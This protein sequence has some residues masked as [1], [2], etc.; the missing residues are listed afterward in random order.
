MANNINEEEQTNIT[1]ELF[2]L[3]EYA[4]WELFHFN[5]LKKSTKPIQK[6]L[7]I[8]DKDTLKQWK[9]KTGYNYFKKNIFNY[10][11]TTNKLKNQKEKI[12]VEN[13]KLN[14]IWKKTLSDKKINLKEN[15]NSINKKD[16]G[17]F[18]IN[19]KEKQIDGN[20]NYEIISAKL[21]EIF[22]PFINYKITING[23]YYKGKLTIPLNYKNKINNNIKGGNYLEVFYINNKNE[24]EDM[25]YILPDD[26]NICNELEQEIINDNIENLIKNIFSNITEKEKIKEF[27]HCGEDGNNI[28]YKVLNKK[29]FLTQ[30]NPNSTI[31]QSIDKQNKTIQPEKQNNNK[32]IKTSDKNLI[33]PQ[34]K[35][36]ALNKEKDN[37]KDKDREKKKDINKLRLE[38]LQ[39]M[40]NYENLNLKI[41]EKSTNLIK[42]QKNLQIAKAK[43]TKEKTTFYN[44]YQ[45]NNKNNSNSNDDSNNLNIKLEDIKNKCSISEKEYENKQQELSKLQKI[46]LDKEKFLQSYKV[47]NNNLIKSKEKEYKQKN[48]VYNNEEEQ[49]EKNRMTIGSNTNNYLIK[50]NDLFNKEEILNKKEN[51]LIIKEKNLREREKKLKEE[52]IKINKNEKELNDKLN[53]I[54]EK[55]LYYKNKEYLMNVKKEKEEN[56]DSIDIIDEKE[57]DKIQEELEEEINLENKNKKKNNSGNNNS[58]NDEEKNSFSKV[59]KISI[60]PKNNLTSSF[61]SISF[62]SFS[63]NNYNNNAIQFS[64]RKPNRNFT[65][66]SKYNS[67]SINTNNTDVERHTINTNFLRTKTMS[68]NDN[69]TVNNINKSLNNNIKQRFSLNPSISQTETKINKSAPSLG[70]E[71]AGI[72][73][74]LNAIL[75]CIA[76]IPEITEGI[77]ELGYNKFFKQ[78]QNIKL[79]RNFATLVNNIFFPMKFNNNTKKYSPSLFFQT[80]T[81]MYPQDIE[82]P[83]LNTLKIFKFIIE[84]FHDELN[85]KKNEGNDNDEG[86]D[87]VEIDKS[88][89]KEVLVKFLTK[90][91]ENNNSLISKLFYGLIK[92]KCICNDC[93]NN[94]YAFD[95]YSYLYFDLIRIKNYLLN[96]KFNTKKRIILSLNDCL[97]YYRRPINLSKSVKDM[98]KSFFEKFEINS[99]NGSIF[100]GK[101][102][103]EKTG[104]LYKTMYSA[105]TI[106]AIILERGGD[107]NYYIDEVKFPD[108]LNLENYVE[109]NKSIK[110]YYLC[111]V[112]SNLGRNNTFGQFC[113][114]CR[115]TPNGTWF[116]YKNEYVNSC[117]AEDVHKNGVPYMLFYHK[118]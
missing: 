50:E 61:E 10:I 9:E 39:K 36:N 32:P 95:Y 34:S 23:F 59:K 52:K 76:H 33:L 79:S 16:L 101:C 25:L 28:T 96:S 81:S 55:L 80:F 92:Y 54:N 107:D 82:K 71:R 4:K 78:N 94:L 66:I 35:N 11:Y 51:D 104:T 115:M 5:L 108:E 19:I 44:E 6:E 26:I 106:L 27:F 70:L 60:Q 102:H 73:I 45:N 17:I 58:I 111:G 14:N 64:E 38:L 67:V 2:P 46:I 88:N 47:K 7:I 12:N 48:D 41:Q 56:N 3:I 29:Q 13:N 8:I 75:Q 69:A 68:V 93:G 83:Y 86:V 22:K 89:E 98:Q 118:I 15:M 90:L 43:F 37:H 91:T 40:K 85:M 100:C 110:K 53:E 74:N 62:R 1:K 65:L 109:F 113:A 24:T 114:F 57:L 99:E 21:Y 77:L 87:E 103:D 84:T 18:Y 31:K 20:K 105:H 30:K 49:Y 72:P 63:P 117:S 42:N 97:D 116:C 112:V